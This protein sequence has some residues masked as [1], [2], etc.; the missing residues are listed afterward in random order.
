MN[1]DSFK[2]L[3]DKNYLGIIYLIYIHEKD[4]ALNNQQWLICPKT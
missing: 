2:N 4:L 1:S 3:I